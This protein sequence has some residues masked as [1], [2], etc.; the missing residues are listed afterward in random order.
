M[1]SLLYTHPYFQFV[2]IFSP[3][4]SFLLLYFNNFKSFLPLTQPEGTRKTVNKAMLIDLRSEPTFSTTIN[5]TTPPNIVN[6]SKAISVSLIGKPCYLQLIYASKWVGLCGCVSMCCSME[7]FVYTYYTP[8]GNRCFA[9]CSWV[10]TNNFV[11][12]KVTCWGLLWMTCRVCW[13]CQQAVENR[14]WPSWCPTLWS[15]S[16]S[17]SDI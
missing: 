7:P 1:I 17:R 3:V 15:W 8:D 12:G 9:I 13:S 4:A 5:I 14:T 10:P 11:V 2:L 16:T 6:G